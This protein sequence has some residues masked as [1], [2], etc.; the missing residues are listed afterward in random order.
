MRT[1]KFR[2]GKNDII[3]IFDDQGRS[4]VSFEDYAIAPAVLGVAETMPSWIW[5][6]C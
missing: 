5:R 1:G 4:W 2:L 6:Q 3:F